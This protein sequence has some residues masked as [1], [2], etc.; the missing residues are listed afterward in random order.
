MKFQ[1]F[2]TYLWIRPF[3]GRKPQICLNNNKVLVQNYNTSTET[4]HNKMWGE[5]HKS[6]E[7]QIK[8]KRLNTDSA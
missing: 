3:S 2:S 6:C 7:H 5:K 8:I 4:K 1:L